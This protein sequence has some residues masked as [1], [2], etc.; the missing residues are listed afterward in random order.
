[1]QPLTP[2]EREDAERL[3]QSKPL[4]VEHLKNARRSVDDGQWLLKSIKPETRS[5]HGIALHLAKVQ[6]LLRQ[7]GKELAEAFRIMSF[8]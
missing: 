4:V 8:D 5:L 7:A 2:Y 1:M 3:A 6:N